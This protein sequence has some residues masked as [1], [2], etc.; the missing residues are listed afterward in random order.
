MFVPTGTKDGPDVTRLTGARSSKV[1]FDTGKS[2]VIGDDWLDMEEIIDEEARANK[3]FEG[4]LI[5]LGK[6]D[7]FEENYSIKIDFKDGEIGKI[8]DPYDISLF[9]GNISSEIY[10]E[11]SGNNINELISNARGD[12]KMLSSEGSIEYFNIDVLIYA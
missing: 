3:F 5:V 9:E 12:I 6:G 10:L 4:D 7:I 11:S 1:N 2:E 8:L